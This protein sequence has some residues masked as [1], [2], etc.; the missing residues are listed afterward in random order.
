MRLARHEAK[1]ARSSTTNGPKG[2]SNNVD[3]QKTAQETAAARERAAMEY[4]QQ[5]WQRLQLDPLSDES[6]SEE[7]EVGDGTAVR[8]ETDN[9]DEVFECV[10]CNK[11]FMSEASWDNHERSKKHKQAVWR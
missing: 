10:A 5:E 2:A 8:Q 7:E 1:S 4:E 3:V 6:E 11:T 9:G